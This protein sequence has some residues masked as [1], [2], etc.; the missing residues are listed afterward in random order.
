[1]S[2]ARY[3]C[4]AADSQ[5]RYFQA[6]LS[7]FAFLQFYLLPKWTG[8]IY[9]RFFN[10]DSFRM[11]ACLIRVALQFHVPYIKMTVAIAII[12]KHLKVISNSVRQFY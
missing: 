2:H 12:I 9:T 4:D 11:T 5:S 8:E 3:C 7:Q 10:I 6:A 1:M